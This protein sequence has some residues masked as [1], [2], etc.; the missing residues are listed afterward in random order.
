MTLL[1]L[2]KKYVLTS[3]KCHLNMVLAFIF[4]LCILASP[5]S[6]KTIRG[7]VV[8]VADGDTLTLIDDRKFKY[9]VR[10]LG[11]DAP[12]R[13][14]P[15]GKESSENLKWLVYGK[16]VTVEYSKHDR[17]GRIVGKVLISP[18]GDIFCLAVDCMRKMDVGLEQINAG[19]AWHYKRYKRDQ[20][21]EDQNLYSS[22]EQRARKKQL[23]L[24]SDKKPTPP[25]AW[26]RKNKLEALRKRFNETKAKEKTYAMALRMDPN[27]LKQF[28]DE[29]IWNAFKDSGLEEEDFAV[30]F[31]VSPDEI[32]RILEDKGYEK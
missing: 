24:W 21:E 15:Y 7:Q 28:L 25:W 12:E 11:I 22:A 18:Q 10:L 17:Y 14:Q 20:Y 8:K 32:K 29:A 27:Q 3:I 23:G 31:K 6:A 5:L 2:H 13:D 19:T 30:E 4:S 9:R 16:R 26:R 1:A